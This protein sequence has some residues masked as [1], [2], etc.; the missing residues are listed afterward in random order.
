MKKII[1]ERILK[2]EEQPLIE[3]DRTSSAK[4][5]TSQAISYQTLS[6]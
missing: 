3:T 4:S 5:P 6:D 1:Q 2:T